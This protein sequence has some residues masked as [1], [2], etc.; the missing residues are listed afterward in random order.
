MFNSFHSTDNLCNFIEQ[1][2]AI[3]FTWFRKSPSFWYLRRFA[4]SSIDLQNFRVINSKVIWKAID[5]VYSAY[6]SPNKEPMFGDFLLSE[7][8]QTDISTFRN[9]S[10][11]SFYFRWL[12]I[13]FLEGPE[14]YGPLSFHSSLSITSQNKW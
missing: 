5:G 3:L 1:I 7:Y 11:S 4:A 2:L 6:N 13:P 12:R 9:Q 8:L 14:F 10:E